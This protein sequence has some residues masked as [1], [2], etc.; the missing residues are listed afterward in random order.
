MISFNCDDDDEYDD[1]SNDGG[2]DACDDA[3]NDDEFVG[4]LSSNM[5]LSILILNKKLLKMEIN[6]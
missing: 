6:S 3:D 4:I 1:I 5:H 2:D